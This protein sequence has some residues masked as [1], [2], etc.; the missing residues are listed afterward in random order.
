MAHGRLQNFFRPWEAVPMRI[1]VALP[2]ALTAL[3]ALFAASSA[4]AALTVTN[5]NDSG[6]GSLRQVLIEAPQG[7]TIVVPAGTYTLTSKALEIKNKSLTIAGHGAGDTTIRAGGPFGVFEII[8]TPAKEVT[9]GG[10]T[11]RD[12][13]MIAP[14]TGGAGVLSVGSKLTLSGVAVTNNTVNGNGAP[15]SPGKVAQGAGILV[16]GSLNLIASAVTNNLETSVGGSG[17]P[18]NTASAAVLVVGG[19]NIQNST[20]SDN[21]ADARGGQ[22]PSNPEQDGGSGQGAGLLAVAGEGSASITGST[23]GGNIADASGGPGGSAGQVLGGGALIVTGEKAMTISNTTI[24][25][26]TARAAGGGGESEEGGGIFAAA[27]PKGPIT[28]TSSTIA[29]N[30]LESSNTETFGGNLFMEGPI[31]VG[32]TIVAN[33]AGPAGSENCFAAPGLISLGF[34]IDS[35][36]QCGFKAAGDQVNKDPLLGPLQSNGGPTQTMAPA[37]GSPAIDQGGSFG[38]TGDQ[39]GIV[40]PID[41]PSIPNSA[42]AS[43]D[44]SD[45]GAVELQPS[46]AFTL[47]KLTRNKKK[48]TARLSVL[49][50]SPSAG[51][52]TLSG[53]GLKTQTATITGETEVKLLVALSSKKLK[54]ALRKRGKR[55]VGINVT[56]APTGNSAATQSRKA[57]LIKKKRKHKKKHPKPGK[58]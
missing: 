5:Q 27:N 19:F 32:N 9:I 41:L 28:V 3:I 29:G 12:G 6:A 50:P 14:A 16:I 51:I 13:N 57:K 15:G 52:L 18:G 43:A 48:G 1:K 40:R 55:K 36:D 30:R 58:R 7:E 21:R 45:V 23:I 56:Y 33:G 26:N 17:K 42:A 47:G 44:G 8:G 4:Q 46:N 39:R 53:K 34:N 20:I 37:L 22:G 49:L 2:L 11:I 25:S 24:T 31:S 54:K 35:L 10:V 38:L